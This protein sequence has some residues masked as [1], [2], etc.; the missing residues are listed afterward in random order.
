MGEVI[1]FVS[2]SDRERARLVQEARA[3]YESIFPPTEPVREPQKV[4]I[5]HSL[6]PNA[7][8]GGAGSMS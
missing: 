5:G 4:A 8:R 1:R 2:K 3:I 7:H 6:G